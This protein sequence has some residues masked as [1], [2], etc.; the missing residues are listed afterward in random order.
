MKKLIDDF[1][2]SEVEPIHLT[3]QIA[4][5]IDTE[6]NEVE[7]F[8]FESWNNKVY[9]FSNACSVNDTKKIIEILNVLVFQLSSRDDLIALFL[10]PIERSGFYDKSISCIKRNNNEVNEALMSCFA[11]MSFVSSDFVKS[12]F[13]NGVVRRITS[14]FKEQIDSD[15]LISPR[16]VGYLFNMLGNI[17]MDDNDWL[18]QMAQLG[19]IPL[20]NSV[21]SKY[22]DIFAIGS[23]IKCLYDMFSNSINH[24]FL[25]SQVTPLFYKLKIILALIL[26]DKS[27]AQDI[28]LISSFYNISPENKKIYDDVIAGNI[29]FAFNCPKDYLINIV[30]SCFLVFENYGHNT[31]SVSILLNSYVPQFCYEI[32]NPQFPTIF[33]EDKYRNAIVNYIIRVLNSTFR[34]GPRDFLKDFV[35]D[36]VDVN[37]LIFYFNPNMMETA[38]NILSI[39][40]YIL[41]LSKNAVYT[42]LDNGLIDKILE[43]YND[44]NFK[45]KTTILHVIAAAII[46]GVSSVICNFFLKADIIDMLTD[47]IDTP[48][49]DSKDDI[50]LA[51]NIL[52]HL[53]PSKDDNI[54]SMVVP[55][56]NEIPDIPV[57]E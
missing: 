52:S 30:E 13:E 43:M 35:V 16:V 9:E 37:I 56:I 6:E 38:I 17:C 20:C 53:S 24:T 2:D 39:I 36:Q 25:N 33:T 45:L 31:E 8:N 14:Y 51:L 28:N 40:G 22:T 50:P 32:L 46:N 34:F 49:M 42:T 7:N 18:F 11:Y 4:M 23:V 47:A 21:L 41:Y 57:F 1:A 19:L 29:A 27:K 55:F 15:A 10:D 26:I 3:E 54:Y 12:I 44:A 48:L 5:K